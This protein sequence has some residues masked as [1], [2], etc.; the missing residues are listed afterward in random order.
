MYRLHGWRG[1]YSLCTAFFSLRVSLVLSISS[2]RI[3]ARCL[4]E[5][6]RRVRTSIFSRVAIFSGK[7]FRLKIPPFRHVLVCVET[8]PLEDFES[9]GA[10][11][12]RREGPIFSHLYLLI[13]FSI[14]YKF[15]KRWKI[16]LLITVNLRR[17]RRWFLNLCDS[18]FQ[19]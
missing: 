19:P 18:I 4:S 10:L 14:K 15:R 13:H 6:T 2:F 8:S 11:L 5:I 9:V 1:S 17:F 16:S 7:F 3:R 12:T